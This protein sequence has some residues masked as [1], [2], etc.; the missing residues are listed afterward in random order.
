MNVYEGEVGVVVDEKEI[1]MVF[2]AS[3]ECWNNPQPQY[4]S[5]ACVTGIKLEVKWLNNKQNVVVTLIFMNIYLSPR[6]LVRITN[7][8][9][10]SYKKPIFILNRSM[11][12][13]YDVK[14]KYVLHLN[15]LFAHIYFS[16]NAQ[17]EKKLF[18]HLFIHTDFFDFL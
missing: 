15:S 12:F 11:A 5:E 4:G 8:I 2:F 13:S 17:L 14:K 1:K 6:I 10:V 3:T 16:I 18:M 9:V 7:I